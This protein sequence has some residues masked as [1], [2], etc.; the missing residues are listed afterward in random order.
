MLGD[1]FY[2]DTRYTVQT[3][4]GVMYLQTE[5]NACVV[6]K[7]PGLADFYQRRGLQVAEGSS[8]FRMHIKIEV[9]AESK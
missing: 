1:D 9:G 5:G 2:A 3:D 7:H 4:S 6:S 8:L